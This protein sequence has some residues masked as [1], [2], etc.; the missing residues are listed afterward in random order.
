MKIIKEI[1]II[2]GIYYLGLL[3]SDLISGLFFIPGN[4]IGMGILFILLNTGIVKI[5]HIKHT[6][7]F[8][9][10]HMGFFFIPLGVAF[11]V[12]FDEIRPFWIQIFTILIVS[13]IFV[14]ACTG[15][16]VELFIIN[17]DKKEAS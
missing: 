1:L 8:L 7:S 3:I 14:M 4:I 15:K 5:G 16:I 12:L 9:L 10:K 6:S 11:Y 13:N 17:E 2:L